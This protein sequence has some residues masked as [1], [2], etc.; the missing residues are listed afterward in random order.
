MATTKSSPFETLT[1][2]N[3]VVE[4][5]AV[6]LG[7][8]SN[9]PLNQ[10]LEKFVEMINEVRTKRCKIIIVGNGGSA[11]IASHQ[12]V[13]LWKNGGIRA[14]AFNDSSLLTC[15]GNDYGYPYV[16]SKP[17]EMFA[18]PGDLVIAISSSGGSVNILNAVE[19]GRKVGCPIITLSG[20]KSDNPLRDKGDLNF[21]LDSMSY[22]IV[23]VGHLLLV[24]S[25]IDEVIHRTS[26]AGVGT[27]SIEKTRSEGARP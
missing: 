24:H 21:Y 13:D 22:G 6:R 19:A 27:A 14:I 18:D 26:S 25:A 3:T 2:F 4:N 12:S 9:L 15:V 1:G 5:T 8:E 23:E 7:G 16:F 20:F 17:I 11:A 10:G